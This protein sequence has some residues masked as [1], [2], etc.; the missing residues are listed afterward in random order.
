[1]KQK[2]VVIFLTIVIVLVIVS[3]I[4][5]VGMKNKKFSLEKISHIEYMLYFDSN[6]Y[7]VINK[8]GEVIIKAQYDEIDIPNPSKAVFICKYDYNTD[9]QEYNIKV[10][11]DK[12]EPILYQ[13]YIV[14]SIKLNWDNSEVPFEKSVLKFKQ[15]GKYGLIDFN[16]KVKIKAKFDEIE[17][18]DYQEGLILVKKNGKYGV[19]NIN[20][21]YILKE[22]YDIIKAN[23]N[24]QAENQLE[25]L[26]FIVGNLTSEGY[27]YGYVNYKNQKILNTEYDQIEIIN[28]IDEENTYFVAFKDGKAGFYNNKYNILKN[29]YDDIIY[30]DYNKCLILEKDGKQG[31]FKINGEMQLPIEFDKIFIS[32]R[33]INARKDDEVEVYD[34]TTMNKININNII[35]LNE[36]LDNNKYIIAILTNEKYKIIDAVTNNLKNAEYDYL[37]Y[38]GN[39]RFIACK[40]KK[41]G[42]I[43]ANEK[44]ILEFKYDDLQRT[45]KEQ[46]LK[47][48]EKKAE[49]SLIEYLNY[50][51]N[52]E[53]YFNNTS[54]FP[55]KIDN[56]K[57]VDLGY[58]EP[59]YIKAQA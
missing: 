32:G 50:D 5:N 56:L 7:G 33:Y 26:G 46:I 9:T 16:G 18:L 40:D 35:G 17:S 51:G 2:N 19:V 41:F 43:D 31:V 8:N 28:S 23:K 20:G 39:D 59:Y 36:T 21:D 53:K 54:V 38:I 10:L 42:I 13:Y 57:K 24:F 1:M 37:E 11:N 15:K 4:F 34:Y 12:N 22:K 49:R 29:A 3:I 47:A 27:K 14:D 58:G 25:K 44:T 6:K 45:E 52:I 55:E 48:T 30:N